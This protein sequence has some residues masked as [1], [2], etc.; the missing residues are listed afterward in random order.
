MGDMGSIWNYT[1]TVLWLLGLTV[2]FAI[3]G[4]VGVYNRITSLR[5]RRKTA[6]GEVDMQL[7]LRYDLVPKL[8]ET[9]KTYAP[10]EKLLFDNVASTRVIAMRGGQIADRVKSEAALGAAVVNL[11]AMAENNPQIKMD[12]NFR[13]LRA[14]L[15]DIENRIAAARR[16]FNDVTDTYNGTVTRLP[17]SLVA[18]FFHYKEE[19]FFE[20]SPGELKAVQAAA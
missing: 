15:S 8:V 3:L 2:I 9:V 19:P 10:D 20:L 18:Q 6:F 12:A 14:D 16:F 5:T 1:D 17:G 7:K 4:A 13:Q 11:L